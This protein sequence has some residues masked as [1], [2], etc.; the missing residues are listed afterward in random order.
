M[1][2]PKAAIAEAL[3]QLDPKDDVNWTDDG[4]PMVVAVQR[5]CNDQEITRAQINDASPGFVRKIVSLDEETQ[6]P[7]AAV[8]A[9]PLGT[10]DED[11]EDEDMFTEGEQPR[12]MLARHVREAELE[13]QE[14]QKRLAEAHRDVTN[15]QRIHAKK[16]MLYNSKFPPISA[17]QNIKDHLARQQEILYERVTG[18]KPA[19]APVLQNPVDVTMSDRKRSNGRNKVSAVSNAPF[20]PRQS[21]V[22]Y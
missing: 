4:S 10:V 20:L 17:A 3:Q 12:E 8:V 19:P 9:K 18:Q 2:T 5:V 15:A 22:H 13:I 16:L 1:P 6:E 21:A 7:V 11:G 14:A